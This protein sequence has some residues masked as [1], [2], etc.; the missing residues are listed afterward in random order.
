MRGTRSG[1]ATRA[2]EQPARSHPATLNQARGT[3]YERPRR[4]TGASSARPA[5]DRHRSNPPAI[6]PGPT[7]R[8]PYLFV[9]VDAGRR[10]PRWPRDHLG[11]QAPVS[12]TAR[13]RR[14]ELVCPLWTACVSRGRRECI[15]PGSDVTRL[16]GPRP[17]PRALVYHLSAHAFRPAAR[18]RHGRALD[19][20]SRATATY[21]TLDAFGSGDRLAGPSARRSSR[22]HRAGPPERRGCS[23]RPRAHTQ[24]EV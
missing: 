24:G 14:D 2:A 4:R 1:T 6:P 8:G 15:D 12:R 19:S 16:R 20:V 21:G 22:S 9:R 18:D 11:A 5:G 7:A 10:R 3:P 17:C 23:G 13:T